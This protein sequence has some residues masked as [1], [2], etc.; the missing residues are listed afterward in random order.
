MEGKSMSRTR[1]DEIVEQAMLDSVRLDWTPE[2]LGKRIADL[3]FR[4]GVEQCSRMGMFD[5]RTGVR[6]APASAEEKCGCD[7]QVY[8]RYHYEHRKAAQTP[9]RAERRVQGGR[10]GGPLKRW[11]G[12][13]HGMTMFYGRGTED[14]LYVVDYSGGYYKCRRSGL[15]RRKAKP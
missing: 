4:H 1:L 3:S 13:L 15:D 8:C 12:E 6:P 11:S 7:A 10:R 9:T 2:M 5:Y 14:F